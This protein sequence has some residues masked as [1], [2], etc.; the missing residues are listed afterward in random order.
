MAILV[1]TLTLRPRP[2]GRLSPAWAI[3]CVLLALHPV[4][5]VPEGRDCGLVLMFASLASTA[6]IAVFCLVSLW[7]ARC[8]APKGA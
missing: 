4:W 7:Q 8:E 6:V 2:F 3:A 1:I 5:T